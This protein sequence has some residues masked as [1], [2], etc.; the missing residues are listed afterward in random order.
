MIVVADTGPIVHLHWVGASS[1]ALPPESILVVREVWEEI[2]RN[3]PE[4]LRDARLVRADPRG[5]RPE[6]AATLDAGEA[7]AIALATEH[8]GCLVLCDDR[9]ARRVCAELSIECIGSVGLIAQ[10][11]DVGRVDLEAAVR[12]LEALPTLGRL[13]VTAELIARAVARLRETA[14]W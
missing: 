14:R 11:A 12:A 9:A 10:A 8:P 6:L 7:A 13:H 5:T 3:A 2:E 1:W 4:A